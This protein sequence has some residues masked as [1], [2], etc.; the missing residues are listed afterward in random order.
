M[1]RLAY[2]CLVLNWLW[3]MFHEWLCNYPMHKL[4]KKIHPSIQWLHSNTYV[5]STTSSPSIPAKWNVT[6]S[7][8]NKS[9]S[10]KAYQYTSNITSNS[11]PLYPGEEVNVL[12][13]PKNPNKATIDTFI[14]R[15]TLFSFQSLAS[16]LWV[17]LSS[18]SR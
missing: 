1:K 12:Y 10:I 2:F 9:S 11:H 15:R 3:L 5:T 7:I 8:S 13:N 4:V 6:H 18:F 14:Y 16:S 17:F